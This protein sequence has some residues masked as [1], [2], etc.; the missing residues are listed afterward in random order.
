MSKHHEMRLL[1]IVKNKPVEPGLPCDKPVHEPSFPSHRL[2]C[3][4]TKGGEKFCHNIN[5][6]KTK[7]SCLLPGTAHFPP[8]FD[9][10]IDSLEPLFW[11]YSENFV[12]GRKYYF[13]HYATTLPFYIFDVSPPS[14][15][16]YAWH[17]KISPESEYCYSE[18]DIPENNS[19]QTRIQYCRS[20]SGNTWKKITF[21]EN[22]KPVLILSGVDEP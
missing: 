19:L 15:L 17:L 22:Q 11:K 13:N 20:Y 3:I 5:A 8:D 21:F 10:I 14:P 9:K 2:F 16:V 12:F 1:A 18:E 4:T 7:Y 6:H